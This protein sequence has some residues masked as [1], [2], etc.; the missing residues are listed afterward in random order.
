MFWADRSVMEPQS[1][2][3]RLGV[4][5]AVAAPARSSFSDTVWAPGAIPRKDE[6]IVPPAP[7]PGEP[8]SGKAPCMS[9]VR[10][11]KP[12]ARQTRNRR[13]LHYP[14]GGRPG[15][16]PPPG[17]EHSRGPQRRGHGR[18]V[19]APGQRAGGDQIA[20]LRGT[21]AAGPGDFGGKS[22]GNTPVR[23]R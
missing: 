18:L 3:P 4:M 11:R 2:T 10:P 9:S 13:D 1:D 6:P 23:D 15:E 17:G 7:F 14:P 16:E 8:G 19:L 21:P 20:G 5:Q 12:H 22:R